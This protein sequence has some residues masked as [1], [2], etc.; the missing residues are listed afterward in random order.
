M[1]KPSIFATTPQGLPLY[2]RELSLETG[3]THKITDKS[4]IFLQECDQDYCL[5]NSNLYLIFN[6]FRKNFFPDQ[7]FKYIDLKK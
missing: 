1:L 2:H 6:L 4:K 5:L 3:K 7:S